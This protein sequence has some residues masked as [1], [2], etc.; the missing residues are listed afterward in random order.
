M[1]MTIV[2]QDKAQSY[3]EQVPK[4]NF[5]P[6]AIKTYGSL[7]PHLDSFFISYVHAYITHH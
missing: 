3:K 2:V 5:N 4:D 7:H 6:L 1:Q